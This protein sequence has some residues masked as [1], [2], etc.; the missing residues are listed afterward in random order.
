MSAFEGKRELQ[1]TRLYEGYYRNCFVGYDPT[2]LTILQFKE[3]LSD[4]KNIIQPNDHLK[5]LDIGCATGVFLDLA[6]IEGFYVKGIEISEDLSR[7]AREKFNLEIQSDLFEAAF[8]SAQFDVVT[9][10]DV[11]EHLPLS[12]ADNMVK[13]ISRVVR[14]GGIVVIKTPSEDALLRSLAKLI[15]FLGLKRIQAPMHLFY[16]YEHILNFTPY[17]LQSIFKRHDFKLV[18][19]RRK[20]ENPD[21]LNISKVTKLALQFTYLFSTLLKRQHKI[22]QFYRRL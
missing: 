16:S 20:E 10:L 8:P 18:L 6:R 22:V 17:A 2:D 19:Q 1:D 3:I 9:M 15:F 12:V 14:P 11:I 5:L 13:E 4:I 21:R 7:Y